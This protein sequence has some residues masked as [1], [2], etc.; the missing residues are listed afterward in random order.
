[1]HPAVGGDPRGIRLLRR[2]PRL[3]PE[4][5]S[6]A[7][8]YVA[9]YVTKSADARE[10]VPWAV[11]WVNERTGEALTLVKDGRYR[12]WS[13]SRGWGLTMRE[14]R[15]AIAAHVA[16]ARQI[17]SQ[18]VPADSVVAPLAVVPAPFAGAPP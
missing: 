15:A 9:K 1:V 16:R 11:E 12:T 14:V 4:R 3:E 5:L 2:P 6:S 18:L 10:D 13:S 17:A 7:V 8:E